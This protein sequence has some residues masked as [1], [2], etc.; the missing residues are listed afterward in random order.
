MADNR[1]DVGRRHCRVE[2]KRGIEEGL[3]RRLGGENPAW[4]ERQQR[5]TMSDQLDGN[6]QTGP[7][8][9]LSSDPGTVIN[10]NCLR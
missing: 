3:S 1:I 9:R 10:I 6:L 4:R 7:A 8:S 5:A 2:T